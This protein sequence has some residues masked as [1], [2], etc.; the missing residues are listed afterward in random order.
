MCDFIF[1][2]APAILH[3]NLR[4]FALPL[5]A[6]SL[7]GVDG[8]GAFGGNSS[9]PNTPPSFA[10]TVVIGDSLSSGFENGSLLDSQQPNGWESLVGAQAGFTLVL[11]L[12]APP[13]APAVLELPSLGPPPVVTKTSGVTTGRD[14][15]DQQPTDLAVPG[16][17]L[18][19]LINDA[20]TALPT[21]DIDVITGLVLGFPIGNNKSQ[22][23][24]AI[25]LQPSVLFI[26]I[27]NDDALG[28]DESGS[29]SAMT[30]IASFTQQYQQML[31]ALHTQ[32]KATLI[33]AN[34]PD[35]TEAP[36]MTPA[37]TVIAQFAAATGLTQA[38]ATTDLGIQP[39]D[40]INATGLQQ[41]QNDVTAIK[42]G[43]ATTPLTD[44]GVLDTTEIPQVQSIVE[45]YN[46]V[47]AQQVAAVGGVLVDIHTFEQGLAQTGITIN[48]YNATTGFLGG[49]FGL[50]GLHPTNTG[51]AL[52]AN[53]FI[54]TMNTSLKT[55]FAEVNVSAIASADP[56]FGPNVKPTGSAV[57]IPLAAARRADQLIAP[58]K[59]MTT[60][61]L[62]R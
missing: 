49:I 29:A 22:M 19:D 41:V 55:T 58:R 57:S 51:Y 4:F 5:L 3:S 50:D 24:E 47:I 27:G 17:K 10:N 60:T 31:T 12:I 38:Q 54:D 39:G 11:P 46:S 2:G 28:G 35:V 59:H 14:N 30:P 23:N 25:A 18:N 52:I 33:V 40:L 53:Q 45:Q 62:N 48:G 16:Q 32:T 9:K 7:V 26:W 20:P 15:P 56:Y 44:A 34:I 13:G 8:C 36:Y 61:M 1:K 43:A 37:A 21:T 42:L 6:V